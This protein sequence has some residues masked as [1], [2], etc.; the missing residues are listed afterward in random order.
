MNHALAFSITSAPQHME[1]VSEPALVF[2]SNRKR[3]QAMHRNPKLRFQP[4]GGAVNLN[5]H[6]PHKHTHTHTDKDI[7]FPLHIKR[8]NSLQVNSVLILQLILQYNAVK[9]YPLSFGDC[10]Q[11][12]PVSLLQ[13][14]MKYFTFEWSCYWVTFIFIVKIAWKIYHLDCLIAYMRCQLPPSGNAEGEKSMWSQQL[15]GHPQS[16]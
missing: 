5:K 16:W 4:S 13:A 8:L 11:D 1:T 9:S 10:A 12:K 6:M 2:T 7:G 14:Y 3:I 15:N